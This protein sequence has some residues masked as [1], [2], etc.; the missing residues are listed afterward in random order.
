MYGSGKAWRPRVAV[1]RAVFAAAAYL[2]V[3]GG[4]SAAN[5]F[6]ESYGP[7]IYN[8]H[9]KSH[10]QLF[11]DNIHPGRWVSAHAR[12]KTKYYKGVAGR[13]AH[14][15]DLETHQ[16]LIENLGL[17]NEKQPIWIGLRYWCALKMLQWTSDRAFSPSD[18]E[19]FRIWHTNWSAQGPNQ[20]ACDMSASYGPRGFTPVYYRTING[21]TRW[22]AT[23]AGKYYDRYIVEYLTGGE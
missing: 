12:A 20:T 11:R 13:L 14:V 16:F 6:L 5:Q 8:P 22:Q 15:E 4:A 3:C 7:V 10:F 19:R 1:T 2:M 23:G 18:P 21:V 9:T 17:K